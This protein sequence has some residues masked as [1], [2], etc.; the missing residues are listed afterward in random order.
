MPTPPIHSV[1]VTA[2]SRLHFGMFSFGRSDVRQFGGAGA[3]VASPG[4]RVVIRPADVFY[5]DGA[6]SV[7]ARRLAERITQRLAAGEAPPP[8]LQQLRF[9]LRVESAPREHI[10]LGVGTQLGLSIAAAI[11]AAF[12]LPERSGVELAALAGRGARSAIGTHGFAHGGLLVE[13]GKQAS[14][15]ISPLIAQC[16]LPIDWRFLLILPR[17]ASGFAGLDEQAA[18]SRL[19]AVPAETTN[20]LAGEVLLHLLPAAATSDFRTFSAS[21][22]RFGHLAGSCFAA[23]QGGPFAGESTARLVERLRQLGVEGVGQSSWG[24]AVFALCE[25]QSDA[26]RF[27]PLVRAMIEPEAYDCLISKPSNNGAIIEYL[28]PR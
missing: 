11:C 28:D 12:G 5:V 3:M 21:L 7:R 1:A 15:A 20:R 25:S 8:A 14:D 17:Q 22:Y 6:H 13:A 10:G 9:S 4:V 18:F 19:P 16:S 26:D 2:P 27:A 23:A 24:P